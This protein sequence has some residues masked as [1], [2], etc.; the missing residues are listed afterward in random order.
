LINNVE[1]LAHV[2]RLLRGGSADLKLFS[3]SGDVER[4]GVVEQPLGT[5]LS[6]LIERCGGVRGGADLLAFLPGGAS[7]G[8]LFAE[9]A[10]IAMDWESLA[11]AGSALGSGAVL[12]VAEGA[13]LHDLAANLT[14]F[15][16]NESCGKCVPCR[17]GTEKA[18]KLIRRGDSASLE[19]LPELDE[20]LRATSICGLGQVALTPILSVLA[21]F[22]APESTRG[23]ES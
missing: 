21:R 5:P 14:E 16:R 20:V 4:P 15:F 7:T 3:V 12:I 8:F 17:I 10:Q 13:D 19:L 2:P 11:E 18:V 9:H 6:E 23:D 22:P 1:T